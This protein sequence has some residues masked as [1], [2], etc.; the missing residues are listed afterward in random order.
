[1]FHTAIKAVLT[2]IT[3]IRPMPTPLQFGTLAGET[4]TDTA[5]EYR[6]SEGGETFVF[7]SP[8]AIPL[9]PGTNIPFS[10]KGKNIYVV[11]YA[12]E[13]HKLQFTR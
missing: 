6:L 1:M 12:G 8:T 11:D 5:N 2:V 9:Q 3:A 10:I 7:Q 4:H 13:T